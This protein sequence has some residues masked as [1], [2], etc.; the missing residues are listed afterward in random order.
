MRGILKLLQSFGGGGGGVCV[1]GNQVVILR[2]NQNQTITPL[3]DR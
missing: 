2:H 1:W 3:G